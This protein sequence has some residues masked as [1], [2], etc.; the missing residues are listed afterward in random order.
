M[1]AVAAAVQRGLWGGVP[2][3]PRALEA[4]RRGREAGQQICGDLACR[5]FRGSMRLLLAALVVGACSQEACALSS[6][7]DKSLELSV[8]VPVAVERAYHRDEHSTAGWSKN[9]QGQSFCKLPCPNPGPLAGEEAHCDDRPDPWNRGAALRHL[10]SPL[11]PK[12]SATAETLPCRFRSKGGVP[13][14]LATPRGE[15][16]QDGRGLRLAGRGGSLRPAQ[17]AQLRCGM[18]WSR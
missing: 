9:I 2:K 1:L 14:V 4:A 7:A 13:A 15:A 18:P 6:R 10:C 5:D 17:A 3:C 16:Q 11:G 8:A 12:R